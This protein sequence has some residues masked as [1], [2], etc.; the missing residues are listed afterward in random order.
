MREMLLEKNF[1][2]LL[3]Q[4]PG[5]T[6]KQSIGTHIKGRCLDQAYQWSRDGKYDLCR[7][8][9]W[10]SS[11]SDHDSV[12]VEI[13]LGD[14][15]SKTNNC[16]AFSKVKQA[17]SAK[18]FPQATA[19]AKQTKGSPQMTKNPSPAVTT[20]KSA[21]VASSGSEI[22]QKTQ[23]QTTA[24]RFTNPADK[25]LHDVN[26]VATGKLAVRCWM[27][28]SLQ[29]LLCGLD[30]KGD[31]GWQSLQSKWGLILSK[32]RTHTEYKTTH[33]AIRGMPEDYNLGDPQQVFDN[34][35]NSDYE[36]SDVKQIF[37]HRVTE[38]ITMN[39]CSH[40]SENQTIETKVSTSLL[41]PPDNSDMNQYIEQPQ[42]ANTDYT[43]EECEKK[44]SNQ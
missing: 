8:Y 31:S 5:S 28:A 12:F 6:T 17:W 19:Q 23:I 27:N 43:C 13:R 30:H 22:K 2:S 24:R 33:L 16:D 4:V 1:Q 38:I 25:W 15:Q 7:A 32:Y 3:Y 39:N 26:G 42:V 21:T 14:E 29:L 44:R 34:I 9:V 10:T 35:Q 37:A 41:L 18:T 11:F 36:I 40:T 20:A